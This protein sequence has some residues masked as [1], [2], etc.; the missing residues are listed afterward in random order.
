MPCVSAGRSM[1]TCR[2][3]TAK[4]DK[5]LHPMGLI[6]MQDVKEAVKELRRLV[7]D[8][9]LPGAMLPSRGLAATSGS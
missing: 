9:K 7:L 4:V 2:N 6:A 8:L 3:D 5:R 1:T